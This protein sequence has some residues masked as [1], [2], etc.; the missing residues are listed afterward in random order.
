MND[1]INEQQCP[2]CQGVN[3]CQ[4]K[5]D[6]QCW[7]I[8]VQIPAQ[9]LNLVPRHLQHKSCVC[10]SCIALFKDNPELFKAKYI[11]H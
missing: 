7:C 6:H 1:S 4:A 10:L 2:F 5:T 3:S 8:N 9:L 11:H